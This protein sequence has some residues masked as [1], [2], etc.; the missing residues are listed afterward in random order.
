MP[1]KIA[2]VA[3]IEMRKD[4]TYETMQNKTDEPPTMDNI[5]MYC[6]TVQL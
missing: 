2:H 5:L 4:E 6:T 3:T 1:I